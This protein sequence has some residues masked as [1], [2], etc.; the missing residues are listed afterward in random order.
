[1]VRELLAGTIDICIDDVRHYAAFSVDADAKFN[2]SHQ[3]IGTPRFVEREVEDIGEAGG[4]RP[5]GF[6][7][8]YADRL[9]LTAACKPGTDNPIRI[10]I[11]FD[12]CLT[13]GVARDF[14]VHLEFAI[15]ANL[16]LPTRSLQ[17]AIEWNSPGN[18]DGGALRF[19]L[20]RSEDYEQN[21]RR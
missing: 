15:Q 4:R 17:S 2:V 8:A 5:A 16:F 18:R 11:A 9:I 20:R 19:Y 7:A 6:Q 21:D 10:D 1:M 12:Q 14:V 3:A 13:A